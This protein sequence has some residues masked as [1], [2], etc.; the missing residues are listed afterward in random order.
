ML[1]YE[2]LACPVCGVLFSADDDVVACPKCGLP[3]HRNCWKNVGHC[4]EEDKHDTDMQWSRERSVAQP[5]ST[6]TETDTGYHHTCPHCGMKNME[7][8]EFCTRCGAAIPSKEWHSTQWAPPPVKEYTP[9]GQTVYYSHAERIG[10]CGAD[11]VAAVVGRNVPYYMDRFRRVSQ[12]RSG[13]WNWAAFLLGPFWLFYRK[14][15]GLG[16]L[17]FAVS[18]L[19]NILF[20][21]MYAPAQFAETEA[22]YEA[23]MMAAT[24]SPLFLP[25]FVLTLIFLVLKIVL[26]VKGN[27]FYL[28]F[29][30]KKI[31]T[32]KEKTPDLSV[33]ELASAGG[34]SMGLA[35]LFYAL[36][37]ILVEIVTMFSV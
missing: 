34:V 10:E 4:F 14:Q 8:A 29:C 23:A 6:S 11:E 13:G 3:H 37:S 28:H 1:Y 15:F 27:E 12:G 7:Y 25:V 35:V 24:E 2:G 5:T 36:S 9:F 26:G 22:A 19:S 33:N 31:A 16:F 21:V 20:A 32:A 18:M 17:Y 30:I